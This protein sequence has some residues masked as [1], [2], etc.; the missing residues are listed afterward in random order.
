VRVHC[1]QRPGVGPLAGVGLD[2][3]LDHGV[4]KVLDR[5]I[6]GGGDGQAPLVD[7][8]VAV[9]LLEVGEDVV[10]EVGGAGVAAAGDRGVV[11]GHQLEEVAGQDRVGVVRFDIAGGQHRVEDVLPA[12]PGRGLLVGRPEGVVAGGPLWQAGQE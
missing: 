6:Q 4:G 3:V 9:A 5:Q 12:L 11:G 1:Q 7:L 2:A 8:G 10:H